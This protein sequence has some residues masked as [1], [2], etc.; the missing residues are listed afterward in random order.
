MEGASQ[1][2]SMGDKSPQWGSGAKPRY[3][4][5]GQSFPE[6]EAKCEIRVQFVTF[7]EIV[8]NLAFNEKE[9]THNSEENLHPPPLWVRQ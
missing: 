3:G 9:Q 7:V 2:V 4:D 5:W 1:G 8:E 6:A